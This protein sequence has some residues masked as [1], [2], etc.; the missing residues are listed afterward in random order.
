MCVFWYSYGPK[1]VRMGRYVES[2]ADQMVYQEELDEVSFSI[3]QFFSN[4]L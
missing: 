2:L 4:T 1:A 3:C